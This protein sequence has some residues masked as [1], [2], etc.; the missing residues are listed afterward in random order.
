VKI[1]CWQIPCQIVK[2]RLFVPTALIHVY[3]NNDIHIDVHFQTPA[4]VS[5]LVFVIT[6]FTGGL[7]SVYM[8]SVCILLYSYC[9]IY[10]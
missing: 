2:P 5:S 1:S 6:S 9:Y 8:H 3:S 7:A 4:C 10:R